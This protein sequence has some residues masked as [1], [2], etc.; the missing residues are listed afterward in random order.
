MCCNTTE[1]EH[2]VMKSLVVNQVPTIL[3]V[4]NRFR[5]ENNVQIQ[6]AL[7][8]KRMLVVVLKQTNK[9]R[10]SPRDRNE[11]LIN[12]MADSVVGGYIDKNGSLL[13][14]LS[15]KTNFK[16]LTDNFVSEFFVKSEIVY[17]RWTV[18][19]DKTLLRMYYEDYSIHEIKKQ[20]NRSYVA[21]RERIRAITMP[22]DVLK[23][24]EFEELVLELLDIKNG[25][26]L[27]KEWRGD[28]TLGDVYPEN[29]RYP[30]FLVEDTEK[31]RC[32]AIECKWRQ[33]FNYE[34]MIDIFSPEQ[35][36]SYQMFS[37]KQGVP[38]YIILGIAGFPCEPND[39][40]II[41]LEKA[42]MIQTHSYKDSSRLVYEPLQLN[43]FKRIAVD[44]PLSFD[45]FCKYS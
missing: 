6:K 12:N 13:P 33:K 41:P 16:A 11:F 4:M 15:G 29:N 1:L 36:A 14:L 10:W 20:L 3:V 37:Q 19:Q 7:T 26:F 30:D 2:E 32:I 43:S 31:K 21:V 28:K 24:R 42:L 35:L 39:I 5:E 18:D 23:G 44:A 38:V 27:L 34:V 9:K 22:E 40:Y 8:E 45:E 25:K 17:Q